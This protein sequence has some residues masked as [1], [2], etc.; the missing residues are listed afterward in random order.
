MND[1]QDVKPLIPES[2]TSEFTSIEVV[3]ND[4][5]DGVVQIPII[6]GIFRPVGR[7]NE[8]PPSNL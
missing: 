1:A 8:I 3:L 7:A 6:S 2:S 5:R 4:L